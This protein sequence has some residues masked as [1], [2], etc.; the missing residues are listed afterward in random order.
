MDSYQLSVFYT[1]VILILAIYV[2]TISVKSLVN[3]E[4]LDYYLRTS[5]KA[6]YIVEKYGIEKSKELSKKYFIPLSLVICVIMFGVVVRNLFVLV[7]VL[8]RG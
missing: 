7:P 4:D 6:K 8:F 2:T 3:P 1:I 5:H